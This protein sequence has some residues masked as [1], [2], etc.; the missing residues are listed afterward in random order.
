MFTTHLSSSGDFATNDCNSRVELGGFLVVEVP[1]PPECEAS[2]TVRECQA[3]QLALFV[4][5]RHDMPTPAY[6]SGDMNAG[7]SSNEYATFVNRGWVDTHLAAGN[8]ECDPATGRGCTSGRD[9]VGG[10]LER[11]ERN[12]DQRIDFVFLVPGDM[13]LSCELVRAERRRSQLFAY[14]PNPFADFCGPAP[15][16]MCWV[17]DHSGNFSNFRCP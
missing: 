8:P 1:C 9:E 6:V 15:L 16:P 12:V 4:D 10:D 3:R 5:A 14:E 13:T 11:S 7:P 2:Q 17:S